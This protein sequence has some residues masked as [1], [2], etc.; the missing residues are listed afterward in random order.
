MVNWALSLTGIA[1]EHC[2]LL[3]AF[4]MWLQE[5]PHS[6]RTKCQQ[7]QGFGECPVQPLRC[8]EEEAHCPR[9]ETIFWHR[10]A[11]RYLSLPCNEPRNEF[12]H[13]AQLIVRLRSARN[14][15]DGGYPPCQLVACCRGHTMSGRCVAL[16]F[17]EATGTDLLA[18]GFSPSSLQHGIFSRV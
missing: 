4:T 14:T 18:M 7:E 5:S 2:C 11:H 3:Y 1:K 9:G 12:C 16:P 13:W 10:N 8:T 15:A 17:P 6:Y